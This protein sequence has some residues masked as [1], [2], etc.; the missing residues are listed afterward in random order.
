[1]HWEG[2][3]ITSTVS[4]PKLCNLN[5]IVRRHEKNPKWGT[6]LKTNALYSSKRAKPWTTNNEELSQIQGALEIRQLNAMYGPG[7]DLGLGEKMP[8]AI[9]WD[10]WRNLNKSYRL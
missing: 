3:S 9:E 8:S 4:L 5:Y 2:Y 10:N 7:L 6:F 1:M